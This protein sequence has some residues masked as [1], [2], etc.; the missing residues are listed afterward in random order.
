MP[1]KLRFQYPATI[2][3]VMNRGGRR[4]KV[5]EDDEDRHRVSKDAVRSLREDRLA[6]PCPLPDASFPLFGKDGPRCSS[7]VEVRP[8]CRQ[9]ETP[10]LPSPG[11]RRWL[12][13]ACRTDSLNRSCAL[14]SAY[15]NRSRGV[16]LGMIFWLSR[17]LNR[18]TKN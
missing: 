6:G 5:F 12:T 4:E 18:K 7:R 11:E 15:R 10:T 13:H 1:R 16:I 3:H 14:I 17:V 9:R 8:N 2:Y